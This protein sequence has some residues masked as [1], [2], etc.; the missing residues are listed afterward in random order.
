MNTPNA[1]MYTNVCLNVYTYTYSYI[2]SIHILHVLYIFVCECVYVSIYYECKIMKINIDVIN[3]L[4]QQLQVLW[5]M[6][7]LKQYNTRYKGTFAL[8][9]N[10]L[11]D[12]TFPL[13][14]MKYIDL[15]FMCFWGLLCNIYT[16]VLS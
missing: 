13:I 5:L 11:L 2:Y 4:Y 16:V 1:R 7:L 10:I 3:N 6:L 9:G 12:I 14:N 15:D 8:Q